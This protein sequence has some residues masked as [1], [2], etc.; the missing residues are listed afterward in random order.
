MSDDI[1]AHVLNY[2]LH[3]DFEPARSY[4][5]MD[6]KFR[7]ELGLLMLEP[8]LGS[9]ALRVKGLPYEKLI[10]V[11]TGPLKELEAEIREYE[12]ANRALHEAGFT[13]LRTAVPLGVI[14][15]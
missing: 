13:K 10:I 14:E 15:L 3:G 8:I 12:K 2:A 6:L 1:L 11:K 5:P 7:L 9:K 4:I